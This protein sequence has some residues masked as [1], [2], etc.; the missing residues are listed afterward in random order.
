MSK[1]PLLLARCGPAAG[2]IAEASSRKKT[3]TSALSAAD[4]PPSSEHAGVVVWNMLQAHARLKSE[5]LARVASQPLGLFAA[6][7]GPACKTVRMLPA[8]GR[9]MEHAGEK[10]AAPEEISHNGWVRVRQTNPPAFTVACG[11]VNTLFLSES[12]DVWMCGRRHCVPATIDN[13]ELPMTKGMKRVTPGTSTEDKLQTSLSLA[14]CLGSAC[15]C[16]AV[17][18]P[19]M[20]CLV[21]AMPC[22]IR[23]F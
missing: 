23:S 5:A 9:P 20:R 1:R 21:H 14:V 7:Q 12:G 13:G 4:I 16:D 11:D 18:H 6:G 10:R 2:G 17:R 22:V 15:A 19:C 3:K 8:P